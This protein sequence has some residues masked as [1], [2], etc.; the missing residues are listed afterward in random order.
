MPGS[1]T[2]NASACAA[3]LP[4]PLR[5]PRL[6]LAAGFADAGFGEADVD[7]SAVA[8]VLEPRGGPRRRPPRVERG[9]GAGP[10]F[11]EAGMPSRAAVAASRRRY[12]STSGFSLP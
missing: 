12:A 1:A 2:I 9:D 11:G 5:R 10:P 7:A 3:R 6:R 8:V 4:T